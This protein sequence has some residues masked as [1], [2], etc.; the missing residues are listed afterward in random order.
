MLLLVN[1]RLC[2][3]INI[4]SFNFIHS[5][6]VQYCLPRLLMVFKIIKIK[7]INI[8]GREIIYLQMHG[9]I[10]LILINNLFLVVS[11]KLVHYIWI[12]L[13]GIDI[14]FGVVDLVAVVVRSLLVEAWLCLEWWDAS[15][16]AI[17]FWAFD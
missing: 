13:S 3:T 10:L 4:K 11:P 1:W 8:Q 16:L 14:S 15:S 17:V 12:G 2:S 5:L 9:S 7:F 6:R